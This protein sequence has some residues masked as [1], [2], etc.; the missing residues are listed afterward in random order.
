[1]ATDIAA[2]RAAELHRIVELACARIGLNSHGAELIKYTVNAVYRLPRER[3]VLRVASG[4][5]AMSRG[6][7][8]VTMARWL[9][10]RDAPIATLLD[11]DQPLT[12]D[13]D[14]TVTFWH[15]L[16]R[17]TDWTADDL[18]SPLHRL[19]ALDLDSA[20]H[21]VL[22]TW[23]PFTTA[24]DRLAHA[25]TTVLAPADA[26]WLG[27]Q[28][29]SAEQ[30]FRHVQDQLPT[31]IIHGDPHTG[32]LLHRHDDTVLCDLDETGIGPLA[33]DLVPQAVGATRF[34]RHDFYRDFVHAYGS[35]VR[36]DP[37]WPILSRIRELIM[38]TSVLPDL[39]HR[40]TVAAQH[41]H[42]LATLRTARHDIAWDL[43]I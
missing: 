14:Y 20:D 24:R 3:V 38:V 25:D 30:A 31:G 2:E 40:P 22:P 39:Q 8:V 27:E 29:D 41:A 18:A 36:D 12:V 33:Y 11:A 15:E 23:D 19:H 34:G 17:R 21:A 6:Q 26:R 32:N 42:R 43:Y 28:W 16:G 10:A 7:R 9:H 5:V 37:A 1:M 4:P 13:G 35:E